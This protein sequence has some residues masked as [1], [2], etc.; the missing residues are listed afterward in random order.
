[1]RSAVDVYDEAIE[2]GPE[3]VDYYL[4]RGV[5]YSRQG[6]QSRATRDLE[7]SIALLPTALAMNELGTLSLAANDR[8]AA[9]QYFQVAASAQG[10]VGQQAQAA[11]VR[12]GVAENPA[13]SV[14]VHPCLTQNGR[15]AAR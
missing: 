7:A 6:Q 3:Y 15:L 2:R 5:A 4:G 8:N 9:K 1:F 13:G 11:F 14:A 10:P 12:L